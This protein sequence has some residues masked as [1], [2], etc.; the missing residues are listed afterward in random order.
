M[1]NLH[2]NKNTFD[3]NIDIDTKILQNE[4][5][6]RRYW[7]CMTQTFDIV[8]DIDIAILKKIVVIPIL[9]SFDKLS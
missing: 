8:I 5:I 3:S 1:Q 4:V 2:L 7:Y 9:I 6:L